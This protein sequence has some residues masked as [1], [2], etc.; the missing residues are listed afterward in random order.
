LNPTVIDLATICDDA[1]RVAEGLLHGKAIDL[2]SQHPPHLHL[3]WGDSLRTQQIMINL[4][5]NAVKFTESGSITVATCA[6]NG[7][8]VVAVTD[9]GI[10]I[11][12]H[13]Q[14]VIFD[15]FRQ[16][17]TATSMP[18]GGTGLGLSISQQLVEL[19]GGRIWIESEHGAGSRVSFTIPQ[20]SPEQLATHG[21][22]DHSPLYEA[23]RMVIFE[24][25]S[26]AGAGDSPQMILL[27]QNESAAATARYNALHDAGYV[28]EQ[29]PLNDQLIEI[30]ELMLPDL[31][32]VE[33]RYPPGD[34]SIREL[35]A[36][37]QL[38]QIAIIMLGHASITG[39]GDRAAPVRYLSP[40]DNAP[41]KLIALVHECFLALR[42]E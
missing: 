41:D 9:T 28:V 16:G 39:G 7:K 42:A 26:D 30:A 32:I 20:A 17:K 1:L 6:E 18:S 36:A 13:L 3:A 2:I 23:R 35:V 10:G 14:D 34:R 21:S 40:D 37:P 11:P 31:M 15:R 24:P 22:Q 4:L 12:E 27:A 33:A 5:S 8:I 19:Q 29:T 25:P 38:S